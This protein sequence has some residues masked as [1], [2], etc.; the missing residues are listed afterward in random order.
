MTSSSHSSR[1]VL[2]SG[3]SRHIELDEQLLHAVHPCDPPITLQGINGDTIRV[4]SQ[5]S[6]DNCHDVLLAPSALASVR[7]VGALVDSRKACIAFTP[8]AAYLAPLPLQLA[9]WCQIA[10]RGDDGLFHVIPGTIPPNPA[11]PEVDAFLSVPQQIK[12]EA[13]LQLHRAL[14][15]ASP[16]RMRQVLTTCPELAPSLK[17]VD[18]RLFT[19]CDG[20]GMGKAS[21]PSAPEKASVRA[22]SFGYRI[23]ADTSGTIRPNTASGCARL[24]VVVDDASRWVFVSLLRRADMHSVAAALRTTLRRIAG[25]EAVLRT[26][27]LR[28]DNGTEFKNTEVNKLLAESDV[29]R[30]LTCVGTSHQ[31]GVAERTIGI[32]FATARTLLVDASLPPRFWGEAIMCAAYVRNRLPSS[33]NTDNLSPYEV[34]YGRRPDLR[35]LRPFGVLAFVRVQRHITKVQPRAEKGI[36]LGYGESVSSQ[37]GWRIFLPSSRSVITTTAVTFRRDLA[38]SI[39]SRDRSL[40]SNT[41]PELAVPALAPVTADSHSLGLPRSLQFPAAAVTPADGHADGA[42]LLPSLHPPSNL[43]TEPAV[44]RLNE[45]PIARARPAR[46]PRGRPPSNSSWDP[47]SGRYVPA[48]LASVPSSSLVWSMVVD[49]SSSPQTPTT[50]PQAVRSPE[51]VQWRHAIDSELS[52]LRQCKT[53]RVV[54]RSELPAGAHPIRCKWVFKIKRDQTNKITRFKARLTACGYAQR[55]GR[56]Y[57]ETFAP[58]ATANSIRVLFA[59][60]AVLGLYV[61]QHDVQTAFLYGVLPP[62]QRVYLAVP[63]GLHLPADKVLLCLKGIYGLKQAPRLF[64]QHLTAAISSFGYAQSKSD[65]CVFFKQKGNYISILAIVVDDI[66]HVASEQ[67]IIDNFTKEMD[68]R[69]KMQHL[70]Q[71][72]FMIGI[73]IDISAT[74]I[75]LSQQQYIEQA[76]SKF[77][78]DTAAPSQVPAHSSGCL[79]LASAGDSPLLDS[80][81]HPYLS[82]V[83]TLLWIT[84][85]R[86]DVQVAV[87]RACS[88]TQGATMA[89]WRAALRILRYLYATRSYAIAYLRSPTRRPEVSAYVDAAYGNEL[90]HHSRRGHLVLLSGCLVIWSTRATGTVCQSTSEAEFA[91]ANECVKDI[92]WLRGLLRELGFIMDSPSVVHED[93]QATIAM[94]NNH[95]VSARNRHFCIRMAWLREQAAA[96]VVKFTFVRSQDNIADIFTKILPSPLF[97]RLRDKL[98]FPPADSAPSDRS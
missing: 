92:L 3:A 71:P 76:A 80:S 98:V 8:T 96:G 21:R 15:H 53:W 9:D 57:D 13:V 2:D 65:P 60:A 74:S 81:T 66:L 1:T 5:G 28:S 11:R 52:S 95:L 39:S 29:Q 86:P 62:G 83:G 85:T 56:D 26:K 68:S 25:D 55:L 16:R 90:G 47:I 54:S 38:S 88:H 44:P 41:P 23:H 20:C 84:I 18:V 42:V 49:S 14:A 82:L 36:M 12:R 50:F 43:I 7:S 10:S 37:K 94:I 69:Y 78:Q 35:H 97:L 40:V 64:N 67:S 6:C 30:E 32:L 17:P 75:R 73:K 22:T 79:S 89:H 58:V 61:S 46:R 51:S 27:Y 24:L 33:A 63:E 91:A 4:S 19:S 72:K 93:N 87:S 45:L 34:R 48:H 70:G 59:L 31:N 77:G